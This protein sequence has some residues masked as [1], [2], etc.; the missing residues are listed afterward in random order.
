VSHGKKL[1]QCRGEIVHNLLQMRGGNIAW[2]IVGDRG[3]IGLRLAKP[4]QLTEMPSGTTQSA[5]SSSSVV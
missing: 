4:L 3:E 1:H 2:I 5:A